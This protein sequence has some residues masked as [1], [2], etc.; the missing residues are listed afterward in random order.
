MMVQAHLIHL[1]HLIRTL[2]SDIDIAHEP[3]HM[4]LKNRG[5]K[6]TH[7]ED[8]RGAQLNCFHSQKKPITKNPANAA[9]P[10]HRKKPTGHKIIQKKEC[11]KKKN[12][13]VY[14]SST[15]ITIKSLPIY[16]KKY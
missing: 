1:I 14:F 4:W 6:Q 11:L 8:R 10:L 12:N 3:V 7:A 9:R 15:S 5:K 16:V 2:S 13:Y